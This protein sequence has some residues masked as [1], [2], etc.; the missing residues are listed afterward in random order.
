LVVTLSI[1]ATNGVIS[2]PIVIETYMTNIV[3]SN[4]RLPHAATTARPESNIPNTYPFGDAPYQPDQEFLNPAKSGVTVYNP[5]LPAIPS[6]FDANG[7]PA[8]FTNQP[9][10]S[11]NYQIIY[12]DKNA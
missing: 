5:N 6:E 3:D 7:N 11:L 4:A 9:Y 1:M 8:G 10:D 2:S 12:N